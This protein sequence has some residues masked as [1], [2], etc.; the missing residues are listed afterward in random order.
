MMYGQGFGW[1]WMWFGG[2]LLLLLILAALIV[3]IVRASTAG[4]SGVPGQVPP[5]PTSSARQIAEERLA[6]GEITP[7]EFRQ[8]ARALDERL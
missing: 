2:I 5:A 4:S 1:G 6:R 7:D 8:I 3:L